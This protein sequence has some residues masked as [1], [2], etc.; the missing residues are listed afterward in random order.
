LYQIGSVAEL[1]NA[2]TTEDA[3][4]GQH[5]QTREL[6]RGAIRLTGAHSKKMDIGQVVI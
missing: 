2:P 6:A 4:R 3:F 5:I 1:A